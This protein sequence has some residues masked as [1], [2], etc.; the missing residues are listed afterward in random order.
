ISRKQSRSVARIGRFSGSTRGRRLKKD[1]IV[2]GCKLQVASS[3]VEQLVP[4]GTPC[5][6]HLVTCTF[7]ECLL[8][9]VNGCAILPAPEWAW[10]HSHSGLDRVGLRWGAAA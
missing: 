9:W 10:R 8:R 2:A 5:N 1:E 3:A 6:L 4:E 7:P